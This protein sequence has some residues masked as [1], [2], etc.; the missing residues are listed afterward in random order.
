[1]SFFENCFTDT[2]Q[3]RDG[4]FELLCPEDKQLFAYTRETDN[5]HL[6]VV[7]N[8]SGEEVQFDFPAG[9]ENAECLI[10]NYDEPSTKTIRPYEAWML[11]RKD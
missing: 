5:E 11:C 2:Q 6:L 9:Y 3:F 4:R 1:M 7:C 8:F 10:S